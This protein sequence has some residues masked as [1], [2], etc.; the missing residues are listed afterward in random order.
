[1]FIIARTGCPSS[2]YAEINL[3]DGNKTNIGY[4]NDSTAGL[5]A[6]QKAKLVFDTFDNGVK[7]ASLGKISCY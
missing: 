7:S 2:V 3:L 4:T 5:G 1:M 6:G